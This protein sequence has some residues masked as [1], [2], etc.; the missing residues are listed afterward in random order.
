MMSVSLPAKFESLATFFCGGSVNATACPI[1]PSRVPNESREFDETLPPFDA[2]RSGNLRVQFIG[3]ARI[4]PIFQKCKRFCSCLLGS[5]LLWSLGAGSAYAQNGRN[6]LIVANEAVADSIDVARWYARVRS[7]PD[8][9]IVQVTTSAA[10]EIS[11]A[12]FERD[13]QTPITAWLARNAAQDRILYIVLTR[14]V[15][16]RISGTRGR[17]G[18]IA[19]VDSELALLYRRMTGATVHAQGHVPNPYFLGNGTPDGAKPFSRE[20]FDIYLVTRLDGFTAADAIALVE[21]GSGAAREGRILLDQPQHATDIRATWVASAVD[22]LAVAFPGR[23]VHETTSRALM[24]E[25]EVLGYY[26]WGSN[27]PALAV[28]HPRLGFVPGAL[29]AMFV[30][31]DARTVAEPPENWKPSR[32]GLRQ[33][34]GGSSQSLAA[35]LVRAGVTGVS[36]QVAEPY[37]DAAVRPDIL[38]PGY[39]KGLSL[40][41]AF[42]AAIP[43]LSWQTVVFGDP[44][45]APFRAPTMAAEIVDAVDPETEFPVAFSARRLA[46]LRVAGVSDAVLKLMIKAEA[47]EARADDA[48]S[49]EALQQATRA[50]ERFIPAWRALATRFEQLRRYAEANEA[51]RRLLILD[52]DDVPSLNN[53]A[54]NLAVYLEA[55]T[56]ALAFAQRA[57]RLAKRD[58][59]VDDT[60]GWIHHLL[61]NDAEAVRLLEPARRALPTSATLQLH[62]A[63]VFRALGRVADAD[64]ALQTAAELDPSLR[65]KS[66]SDRLTPN[67][68]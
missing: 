26:S 17:S 34:F 36:G 30:S 55:P 3:G 42:Y 6:V 52:P 53:L 29:A 15:P 25:T 21:R 58:P 44:L 62:V 18:T 16:L 7:V 9:H 2:W 63:A 40:A 10:A 41:E 32:P 59:L 46:N 24:N 8:D 22:R 37:V 57:A 20:A 13:I 45:C 27:D 56:E 39:L 28:R 43:Y 60:L 66:A 49:I 33:D 35:D 31:T 47:R 54:Y 61:G 11:R 4:R 23:I 19:S 1:F 68:R 12:A 48:G 5:L 50:D 65:E 14:G 64:Q 38:F 67:P 51:Y